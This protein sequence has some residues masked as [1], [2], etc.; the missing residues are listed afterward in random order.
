MQKK[1]NFNTNDPH[2]KPV[3][4][5]HFSTIEMFT[6]KLYR[7]RLPTLSVKN[8]NGCTE[9]TWSVDQEKFDIS[10]L[11]RIFVENLGKS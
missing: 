6:F 7:A 1:L 11:L 10:F 2:F 3:E 8:V 5:V 9:K 4:T